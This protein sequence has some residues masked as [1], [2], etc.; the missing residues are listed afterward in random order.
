MSKHE[1]TCADCGE[2]KT[3]VNPHGCGGVGYAIVRE[4]GIEKKVCYDCCGKR[5]RIE[6]EDK[7]RIVL[8]LSK[9]QD[10]WFVSNW[11]GT[12]KF[13]VEECSS[14]NHNIAGTRDD[15]WFTGPNGRR[16]WGVCYGSNTQICRCRRLKAA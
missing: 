10:G 11:P 7:G 4:D 8:Y 2:E 14:G 12:L 6:M 15:V 1:F 9:N 16:W 3:H 5:D 13:R